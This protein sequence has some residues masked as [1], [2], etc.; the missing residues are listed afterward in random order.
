MGDRRFDRLLDGGCGGGIF[1]PEL[2]SRCASLHAIDVHDR[3]DDVREMARRNGVHNAE[4]RRASLHETGYASG[5]FDGVV[6][7][8]V[9]EFVPDLER[10][11]DELQRVTAP[12]GTVFVGFPGS[13]P[14]VRAGYAA[15]R[16]PRSSDVH[17]S[18]ADDIRRA[19][20]ARFRVEQEIRFPRLL[21]RSQALYFACRCVRV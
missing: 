14:F 20:A 3:L 1:L 13:N 9:L 5:A 11:A 18:R 2:A 19:L 21:P 16:A 15:I 7:V 4:I 8:S 6:V 10:A 17:H 12:G